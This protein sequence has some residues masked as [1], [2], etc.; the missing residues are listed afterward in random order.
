MRRLEN[1]LRTFPVILLAFL[2]CLLLL[3]LLSGCVA[4]FD[5][6]PHK[7]WGFIDKSGRLVIPYKFDDLARDQHGGWTLPHKT[8]VNFSEGLCAVRVGNK[9]G[10]I[11]KTGAMQV[12]LKYDS[13]GPFSEGLAL[14]RVADR[15]GYIDKSGRQVIPLSFDISRIEGA[16]NDNPDWD[17]TQT[18]LTPLEFSEGLAVASRDGKFGFIDKSGKFVIEPVYMRAD[19]FNQGFAAVTP[20]P[21]AVGGR[22]FID[23]R[24]KV[25]V[26]SSKDCIDFSEGVFLAANGKYDSGRRLFYLGEDGKKSINQDFADARIFSEGLAAVA[27]HFDA[28]NENKAYGYVD[29]NGKIVIEPGF[30]IS[31]NNLAGNFRHG[32]AVV[33]RAVE[34]ALGNRSNLH[35]IIDTTG[36]FLVE[37]SYSH[38]S[39]YCDGLARA[40]IDNHTVYLDMNGKVAVETKSV[41]GNSFSEGLAA[42][43][44]P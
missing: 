33:S 29:K 5:K 40:I 20:F 4:V 26:P 36:R 32:R 7:K 19:A 38:I 23:K 37:P 44:E 22:T 3:P 30:D 35:G 12:P 14:V 41:W 34:D 39:S 9:W 10:Y 15:Y 17:F 21:A 6:L 16:R 42:V 31:G 1:R 27:P 18:V 13:A 28:A 2:L 43:M 24:G 25:V 8:F 11:D